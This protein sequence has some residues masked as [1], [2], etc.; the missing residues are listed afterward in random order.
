MKCGFLSETS[1]SAISAEENFLHE[2]F[3]IVVIAAESQSQGVHHPLVS[4][5]EHAKSVQIT[6]L[7][8][9]DKVYL[10]RRCHPRFEKN[11]DRSE[12]HTSELQSQSNL[13]CRL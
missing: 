3:G 10:V 13:V 11:R 7:G 4:G 1:D 5:H 6:V 9:G 8:S 12:E 2:I